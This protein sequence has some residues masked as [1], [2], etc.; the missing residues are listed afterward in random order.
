MTD[1]KN[2]AHEHKLKCRNSTT[3]RLTTC[4]SLYTP[5]YLPGFSFRGNI[6]GGKGLFLPRIFRRIKIKS[7]RIS[8]SHFPLH[9]NASCG[10]EKRKYSDTTIQEKQ[11][12]NFMWFT[13]GGEVEWGSAGR[14]RVQPAL[15]HGF[16][17]P[18][19]HQLESRGDLRCH[20]SRLSLLTFKLRYT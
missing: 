8:L 2:S 3:P 10:Q 17:L 16:E 5:F 4:K 14:G 20:G 1:I 12:Y 7:Q 6:F 15:L 9:Q 11:E 13:P 18:P 19:T